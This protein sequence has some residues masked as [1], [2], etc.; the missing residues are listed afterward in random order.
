VSNALLTHREWFNDLLFQDY[1]LEEFNLIEDEE[2]I[3]RVLTEAR[4]ALNKPLSS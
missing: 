1:E 4:A 2:E 3:S